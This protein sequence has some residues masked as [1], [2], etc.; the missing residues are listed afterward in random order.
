MKIKNLIFDW[1]GV[2]ADD[3][4]VVYRAAMAIFS[5]LGLNPISF[6]KFRNEFCL[7]YMGFYR[8]YTSEVE[9]ETLSR[10]F[11]ENYSKQKEG[12]KP[13]ENAAGTLE[14][15]KEM[16]FNMVIQTTQLE[17]LIMKEIKEFGFSG[18]F[19]EVNSNVVDKV[20]TIEDIMERNGFS[21]EDTAYIGD[22]DHDI[23]AAKKAGIM[24]IAS[25][26]GYVDRE[27]LEKKDPDFII[28]DISEIEKIV[29]S[30]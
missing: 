18:F 8:K 9:R 12:A 16:G 28:D 19:S 20:R 5:E 1:S 21:K 15:L 3:L 7:P 25:S 22:M 10:M 4:E 6:S 29:L 14:I 11:Y 26:Y 24:M 23:E 17:P 13:Y 2:I 30:L 27:K